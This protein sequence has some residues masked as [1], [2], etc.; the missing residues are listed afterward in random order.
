MKLYNRASS[1]KSLQDRARV[2]RWGVGSFLPTQSVS[3]G[4]SANPAEKRRDTKSVIARRTGKSRQGR[5]VF[6]PSGF[7]V[8]W[9][10]FRG[11]EFTTSPRERRSLET[12]SVLQRS[13]TPELVRTCTGPRE[14]TRPPEG[15]SGEPPSERFVLLRRSSAPELEPREQN[16]LGT[17]GGPAELCGGTPWPRLFPI[18]KEPGS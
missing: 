9:R 17:W 3:V 8:E 1:V 6:A 15:R 4:T 11:V 14:W 13:S 10:C 7:L 16:S 18:A 5:L 12:V 2:W